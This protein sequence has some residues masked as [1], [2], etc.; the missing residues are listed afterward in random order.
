MQDLKGNDTNEFIYKTERFTDLENELIV[1]SGKEGG[2][3]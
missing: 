2:K 3:G 1:S